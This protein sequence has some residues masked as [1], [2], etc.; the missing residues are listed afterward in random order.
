MG[1]MH[2][3]S[4]GAASVTGTSS[5]GLTL[6]V[7]TPRTAVTAGVSILLAI[8]IY[9]E[10]DGTA[11]PATLTATDSQGNTYVQD[12]AEVASLFHAGYV[13]SAHNATALLPGDTITISFGGA[14]SGTSIV[15]LAS[16]EEFTGLTRSSS[17]FV[18]AN[19]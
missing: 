6:T 13:L 8:Q 15:L 10:N 19:S 9:K 7:S 5:S 11:Y 16:G 3:R 1:I 17:P 2:L 12:R 4:L 18:A 14:V